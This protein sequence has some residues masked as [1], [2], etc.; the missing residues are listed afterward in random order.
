MQAGG[1]VN[2]LL[3][4]DGKVVRQLLGSWI[5]DASVTQWRNI[6]ENVAVGT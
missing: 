2:E 3:G 4:E 5:K 6:G 1:T